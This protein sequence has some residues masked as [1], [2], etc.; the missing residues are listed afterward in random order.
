[1][2]K[3]PLSPSRSRSRSG[4]EAKN[5]ED[6]N[7]TAEV[8]IF[9]AA[10]CPFAQRSRL[11]LVEKKIAFTLR[12]IDLEAKPDWF[13]A[14]SPDGKVPAVRRGDDVVWE[15]A[16]INE[17]LD[18][19]YPEPPLMPR[20][21]GRRALARIWIAYAD[22]KFVPLFYRLLA[23][24][25]PD[26]REKA[27]EEMR[28]ALTFMEVEGL[29][30]CGADPYWLGRAPSLVD[31]TFYPFFE[32]WPALA[33]YRGLALPDSCPG[34]RGW[35]GAMSGRES[36]ARIRNSVDFYIRHYADYAGA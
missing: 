17:Y 3:A 22:S 20:D 30:K 14:I 2:R 26:R 13:A 25:E 35:L 4:A 6:G 27:C 15:S 5:I 12:E 18:E 9:S 32:R 33:H 21:P 23:A 24:R 16:V 1:M 29:G 36:V 11:V 10:S 19:V 7:A 31:F 34:L 8:E 28:R